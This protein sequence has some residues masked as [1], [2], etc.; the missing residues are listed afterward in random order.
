MFLAALP[1]DC[2]QS[3]FPFATIP[4]LFSLGITSKYFLNNIQSEL[5][6]RRR[7]L[8]FL[9]KR[10]SSLLPILP[11]SHPCFGLIL[12]L[13]ES[14]MDDKETIIEDY[15]SLYKAHREVLKC[16]KL[17]KQITNRLMNSNPDPFTSGRIMISNDLMLSVTLER[18]IGDVRSCYYLLGSPDATVQWVKNI[19]EQLQIE[20][21]GPRLIPAVSWYRLWIFLHC[22]LLRRV[23]PHL[24]LEQRKELGI[25]HM[26]E[27]TEEEQTYNYGFGVLKAECALRKIFNILFQIHH[28]ISSMRIRWNN[29]GPLGPAFRGRDDVQGQTIEPMEWI[30]RVQTYLTNSNIAQA[31]HSLVFA[32][33]QRLHHKPQIVQPL[34][35]QP[36]LVTVHGGNVYYW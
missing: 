3:I 21:N 24:S 32:T 6:R 16:H 12:E 31:D 22:I 5:Q 9:R 2:F 11:K 15:I 28:Q 18:Y 4:D 10:V 1:S 34:T 20:K 33:F 29:F 25:T 14:L 27:A 35:V 19:L 26:V 7:S 13:Q 23:M 36:P 17:Y 8:F 30:G